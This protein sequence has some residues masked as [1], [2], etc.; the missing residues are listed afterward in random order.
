MNDYKDQADQVLKVASTLTDRQKVVAE[1]FDQK[2]ISF[3]L[4]PL[5]IYSAVNQ[6][7]LVTAV[8]F[9]L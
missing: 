4:V 7:D 3:G 2:L 1:F 9:D 6:W 8:G 5:S